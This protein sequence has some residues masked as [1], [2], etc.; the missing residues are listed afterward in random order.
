MKSHSRD[1]AAKLATRREF[2]SLAAFASTSRSLDAVL[3]FKR[4]K[5]R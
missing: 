2:L 1:H 4:V 5:V 3:L